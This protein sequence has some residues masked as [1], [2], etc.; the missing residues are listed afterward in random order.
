MNKDFELAKKVVEEETTSNLM[1][2]RRSRAVVEARM[3]YAKMLRNYRYSFT[4]IGKSIAKDHTTIMHYISRLDDLLETQDHLMTQYI[5]CTERFISEKEPVIL[6]RDG[7][8]EEENIV[9]MTKIQTL[10]KEKNAMELKLYRG[11]I[12]LKRI[13]SLIEQSTPIGKEDEMETKIRRM[14]NE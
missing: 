4:D 14:L 6:S 8:P 12:R 11:S 1:S 3:I 13:I 2:K 7:F 9:L 10:T 5:R